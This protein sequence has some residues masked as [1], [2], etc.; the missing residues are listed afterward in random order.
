MNTNKILE[1]LILLFKAKGKKIDDETKVIIKSWIFCCEKYNLNENDVSNAI[2]ILIRTKTPYGIE[3]ADIYEI[4]RP[5]INYKEKALDEWEN[6]LHGCRGHAFQ[7]DHLAAECFLKIS[8][9]QKY[10][11]ETDSFKKEQVRREFLA[12]YQDK[13]KELKCTVKNAENL[14][15]NGQRKTLNEY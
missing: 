5:K 3:F 2:D 12:L 4:A 11:Y 10:G 7:G 14:L 1:L 6:I 15:E 13:L 9:F 8:D